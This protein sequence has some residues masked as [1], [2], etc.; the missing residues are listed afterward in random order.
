MG[1]D[2][3]D[4]V[5]GESEGYVEIVDVVQEIGREGS[6]AFRKIGMEDTFVRAKLP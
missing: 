5:G 4:E 1:G 3:E 2:G 6:E